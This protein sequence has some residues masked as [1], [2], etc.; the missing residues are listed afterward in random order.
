LFNSIKLSY[1]KISEVILF[2]TLPN[3]FA[4][5]VLPNKQQMIILL[6]ANLD[7]SKGCI[8]RYY[9]KQK[10]RCIGW[11]KFVQK[12][13]LKEGDLCLFELRKKEIRGK[14]FLIMLVHF[15]TESK[16]SNNSSVRGCSAPHHEV[17]K[18]IISLSSG[19]DSESSTDIASG[20]ARADIRERFSYKRKRGGTSF[21][22][23]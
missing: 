5:N 18:E 17:G 15:E 19:S 9:I 12:N 4:C 8:A 7:K 14:L 6:P 1:Q 2:Q 20:A 21:H 23:I 22:I 16:Q 13:R 11:S 10:M 3:N